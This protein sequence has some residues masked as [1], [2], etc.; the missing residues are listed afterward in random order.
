LTHVEAPISFENLLCF[1][2]TMYPTYKVAC[3][4]KGLLEHDT[5]WENCLQEAIVIALPKQVR[6]LFATLL[7]FGQPLNPLSLLKT[8][9]DAMF[10]DWCNYQDCYCKAILFMKEYLSS[11]DKHLTNFFN[12]KELNEFGY[13]NIVDV[14][15]DAN[16]NID[17]DNQNIAFL[18]EDI[19]KLN[20]K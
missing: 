8:H 15:S 7:V 3:I 13:S 19:S 4:A 20:E 10:D 12:I 1:Y 18:E 11:L 9:L 6:Q 5:E 16:D 17:F 2:D 14:G